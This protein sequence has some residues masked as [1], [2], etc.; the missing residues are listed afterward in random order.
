MMIIAIAGGIG[1]GKSVVS[2][3]LRA[4]G[5]DVYD[6]DTAA[7]RIMDSSAEIKRFLQEKITPAA[8]DDKGVIDRAAV[9]AVVFADAERL[10]LLNAAVHSAVRADM[11]ACADACADVMFVE[12]AI[13]VGSG[14]ADEVDAIWEVVA[15]EDLR[16]KR[17]CA[18]GAGMTAAQALARI[19]AQ[20]A[21]QAALAERRTAVLVNDNAT[22]LFPQLE[23]ALLTCMKNL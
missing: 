22:P 20:R 23:A 8:V 11:H 2:R 19:D 4:M 6:T 9:A 3:M 18:R 16:V 5:Y 15:P 17:I 12:T 1:A 7:R 10:A 21:E 14:I 13:A